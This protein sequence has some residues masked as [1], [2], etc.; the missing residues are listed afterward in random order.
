MLDRRKISRQPRRRLLKSGL[1]PCTSRSSPLSKR[2]TD[3]QDLRKEFVEELI[4]PAIQ[5]N[6]VYE[7]IFPSMKIQLL[8]STIGRLSPRNLPRPPRNCPSSNPNRRKRRLQSRLP[9]LYRQRKR[10]SPF[11]I[12]LLR[13]QTRHRSRRSMASTRILYPFPWSSGPSCLCCRTGH[14]GRTDYCQAVV[15]GREYGPLQL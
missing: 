10:P 9:R 3:N 4:Y 1:L 6:A 8:T 2:V 12:S 5:C 15:H 13:S 11:R 7:V 14:S